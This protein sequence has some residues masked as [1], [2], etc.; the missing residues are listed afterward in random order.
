MHRRNAATTARSLSRGIEP[1][2]QP[3]I[4]RTNV[5]VQDSR[6]RVSWARRNS[7]VWRPVPAT[8]GPFAMIRPSQDRIP[9]T[10]PE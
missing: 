3:Q 7:S 5:P 4:T 2:W 1:G 8:G 9:V 10:T 6:G